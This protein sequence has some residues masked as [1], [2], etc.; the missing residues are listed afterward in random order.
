H[1]AALRAS[2]RRIVLLGFLGMWICGAGVYIALI[3]TTAT[4]GTLI[5]TTS[6]VMV[7]LIEIV[8]FRR[9]LSP[10]RLIGVVL[11]LT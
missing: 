6:P 4:N 10:W 11:A 3:A 1:R 2:W 5:Y 8:V 7:L 9:R